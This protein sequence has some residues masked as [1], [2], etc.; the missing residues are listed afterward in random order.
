M[1]LSNYCL[2][3]DDPL[4]CEAD[5]EDPFRMK[6]GMG[7]LNRYRAL[8]DF[9]V[10]D[11]DF[12]CGTRIDTTLVYL[13]LCDNTILQD[14]HIYRTLGL[15]QHSSAHQTYY[16]HLKNAIKET[17]TALKKC[18]GG[19]QIHQFPLTDLFRVGV[20][21]AFQ[22]LPLFF[23]WV[24]LSNMPESFQATVLD[25]NNG[26][27][28]IV[29]PF[30]S[31]DITEMVSDDEILRINLQR[32]RSG[33]Q[34]QTPPETRIGQ[35][36][37]LQRPRLGAFSLAYVTGAGTVQRPVFGF[38][39][40][41]NRELLVL[42]QKHLLS[43]HFATREWTQAIWMSFFRS[44]K[45]GSAG[46]RMPT[47]LQ[48]ILQPNTPI[49]RDET[50]RVARY[51]LQQSGNLQHAHIITVLGHDEFLQPR[52]TAQQQ[53]VIRMLEEIQQKWIGFA[54]LLP[55]NYQAPQMLPRLV[56]RALTL[57]AEMHVGS[58]QLARLQAQVELAQRL[59]DDTEVAGFSTQMILPVLTPVLPSQIQGSQIQPVAARPVQPLPELTVPN[60]RQAASPQSHILLPGEQATTQ[61]STQASTQNPVHA[62]THN[63]A[64]AS[65]QNP[66]HA[67]TQVAGPRPIPTANER[68]GLH[69]GPRSSSSS[70]SSL[71][72]S[73]GRSREPEPVRQLAFKHN[74]L[75]ILFYLLRVEMEALEKTE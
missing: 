27:P 42:A 20:W 44:L 51:M 17:A 56:L 58:A 62:P 16:Q 33:R 22:F 23:D 64:H 43:F 70:S 40:P 28:P 25:P 48:Q 52:E 65:A 72:Y 5:C 59:L 74:S 26:K 63:S 12:I 50:P 73:S 60:S 31:S 57:L 75:W 21:L 29:F 10:N 38:S 49:S 11:C 36:S 66:A 1:G 30:P 45:A 53:E 61:A 32:M 13:V 71:G 39:E 9:M 8:C 34:T 47:Y 2:N 55:R 14:L 46:Q 19:L 69:L 15:D 37:I 24:P 4:A 41:I 6:A 7:E 18:S 67:P 68:R 3:D 54:L 35:P